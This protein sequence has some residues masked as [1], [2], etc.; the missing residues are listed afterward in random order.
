MEILN[1]GNILPFYA[2]IHS[3]MKYRAGC[4]EFNWAIPLNQG[5]SIPFQ[6]PCGQALPGDYTWQLLDSD[7]EI[8]TSLLSSYLLYSEHEDG[9]AWLTYEGGNPPIQN[10]DCGVYSVV[11]RNAGIRFTAYSEQFRVTNIDQRERAYKFTFTNAKDVDGIIYQGGYTQKFW[12]LDCIFDTPEVVEVIENASDGDSVEVPTFQSVQVRS[13]LKFPYFPDY[14]HSIFPRFK[15]ID[16]LNMLKL[17]TNESFALVDTGLSFATE[18]QD[19][20]FKKGVLFWI[21]S[22]Q[23][24]VGCETNEPM[25]YLDNILVV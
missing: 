23:V 1:P 25:V 11:I 12:L 14:W 9:R 8:I 13:V 16:T 24:M 7:G 20:C 21:T 3:Q 15:M 18:E 2:N 5:E 19:V 6:L 4:K 17:E 10:L 22:T